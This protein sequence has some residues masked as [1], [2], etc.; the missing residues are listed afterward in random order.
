M[1]RNESRTAE[2]LK[3]VFSLSA[4]IFF[5]N[6]IT[7]GVSTTLAAR[8]T[9]GGPAV[10]GGPVPPVLGHFV[11]TYLLLIVFFQAFVPV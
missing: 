8:A 5:R 3:H 10:Q 4:K 1:Y 9:L 11:L 6:C 2:S 7:S